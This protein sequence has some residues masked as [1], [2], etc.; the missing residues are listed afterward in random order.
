VRNLVQIGITS[1]LTFLLLVFNRASA[2]TCT[3][4]GIIKDAGGKP[5]QYANVLLLKSF[6]SS[7]VKGMISDSLGKYSFEN[8]EKGKYYITAS[9]TGMKQAFT[10]IFE[11]SSGKNEIDQGI[12][13][14]MN[15]DLQLKEVTVAVKKPMFEQKI[16][17]MIINVKNSITNAGGTAL[18]VLEKSPGVTVN[19][20][21]NTIAINGKNGVAVMINGKIT[22]ISMDALVQLLESINASNIEKIELITTPPAKYDAEGNAGYINIVLINNPY[23]G[24]SGSYFLTAGYGYRELGAAGINFNYRSAKINL[25]GNYAFNHDHYIQPSIVFTQLTMAGNIVTNTSF[26]NRDAVRQVQNIRMGID[27]QL[28]TATIIGALM[29]GYNNR[30]SMTANNG[31]TISKNNIPDTTIS[32]VNREV[33]QWQNIMANLNF[34]HAFK[35][36]KSLFF[37]VNYIYYKDNNPNTYS[38]T[39]Y[40]NLKEFLYHEDLRSGKI[41][42]INLWVFSSDYTTPLGKKITMEAGAKISL[43]KFTNDVNVDKLKEDIWIPDSNLSANYLLK[44][45]IGAAYTSFN[46]NL[47]SKISMKAGLRY[48]YTTSNLGS[49]ET[50]NIVHRKNGELFPTF[51]ISQKFNDNNSVNFSYS[52][53]ITRPAFNDLAP[54]TIFFDPKTFFSGNPA[55]QLATANAIQASY[56]FKNYNFSLSYTHEVNTIENFYFQTQRIDTVSN[57]L[58]LSASNFKYEQYLTASFSLPFI[59][60]KWWSMQ[61]NIT[62][63]WRQINTTYDNAPVRLQIFDYSFNSTQRF[64]LPKDFSVELTG[65][66][67]SARYFGTEK[68]KPIYQLDAGLQ[69]K[70]GNKKDILRLTAN[71][72]FNSGGY[73]RFVENLPIRSAIVNQSFNFGAV[74]YKLTYTR[75]FGNKALKG[76]RE[77]TTGAEDELLISK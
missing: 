16:D 36:G 64:T 61:N 8:I 19:R 2:Q 27:Y 38:N 1:L 11:I 65:F 53:R 60:T 76:T 30:W 6:D 58:Y 23:A 28:D 26:S 77:R 14:L 25:Y 17:R 15:N 9:F 51:Y 72:I 4:K 63:D 70:L 43:S 57:I 50:A 74:A 21:N 73:Y 54:F 69:K 71:D 37:D 3:V 47:S 44:E 7:L 52:R 42:P 13:Y 46:V 24:F 45:N 68:S 32:T 66:Y 22:Y 5:V 34:Q 33:N 35:A 29:S 62:S 39:Y 18:D 31:T 41:T 75:N 48:E 56:G 49:T 10:K 59:V 55:L 20:Q 12:L 40:N 67:S